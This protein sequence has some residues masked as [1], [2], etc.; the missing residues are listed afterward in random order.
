MEEY[1]KNFGLKKHIAFLGYLDQSELR[2]AYAA[3]DVL[4]VP[5]EYEPFGL[6][7]LEGQRMGTPCIVS[8]VSGLVESIQ[9]TKGGRQFQSGN[10]QKLC[11]CLEQLLADALL[12]KELGTEGQRNTE[13]L[14]N[15]S[16]IARK[17]DACYAEIVTQSPPQNITLPD[18]TNPLVQKETFQKQFIEDDVSVERD[19]LPRNHKLSD[20]VIFWLNSNMPTL[21]PILERLCSAHALK[22]LGGKIKIVALTSSN[23]LLKNI[24]FEHP[25][26]RYIDLKDLSEVWATIGVVIAP[27]NVTAE[28]TGI[29]DAEEIPTIWLGNGEP[30]CGWCVANLDELYALSNKLLCDERLRSDLAPSLLHR[31][32]QLAVK[33]VWREKKLILHVVSQLVT[34]GAETTLLELIKGT[35]DFLSSAV[36]CLGGCHGPLPDE[37]RAIGIDILQPKITESTNVLELIS[38][39]SPDILHLHS[40]SAVTYWIPV[41]RGLGEWSIIESEHVVGIGSGHFGPVDH[42]ASVSTAARDVHRKFENAWRTHGADFSVI[43]NG[44]DPTQFANLPEKSEARAI[45]KLPQN[46][47]IVGRVSALARNK[48]VEEAID[49]IAEL[50]KLRNDVLFVIVGDGPQR[51]QV[52]HWIISRK[53]QDNVVLI[54]ERRDVPLVLRAF[55][56]F[57]YHTT[58]EALGNVILEAIAAGL[59]VVCSDIEGTREALEGASGQLVLN[60]DPAKFAK[61]IDQWLTKNEQSQ[62]VLPEKFTRTQMC[63][64]YLNLYRSVLNNQD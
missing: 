2:I 62:N 20:I 52:E 63:D 22:S 5:S 27:I 54:G 10:S 58:K 56:L 19:S 9:K 49:V 25:M 16:L 50:V 46:R 55:D 31:I 57:A 32:D 13:L 30:K 61:V 42:V 21:K 3:A 41:H 35:T 36:L 34:G 39:I 15:W 47:P 45:L 14:F 40:M 53:L 11:E 28:L 64:S 59:P 17:I 4:V 8:N 29:F 43:Y 12:R 26:I 37:F 51:A 44:I 48:C 18:W 60:G 38:N 24:P 1:I 6:V 7:A 33:K 23:E